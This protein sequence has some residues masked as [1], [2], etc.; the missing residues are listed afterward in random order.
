V[1]LLFL[2]LKSGLINRTRIKNEYHT[3]EID[4]THVTVRTDNLKYTQAY[5]A[6]FSR[7]TAQDTQNLQVNLQTYP[8][9]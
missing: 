1:V 6:R 4:C 3:F 5:S 8:T 2:S 7:A 9:F